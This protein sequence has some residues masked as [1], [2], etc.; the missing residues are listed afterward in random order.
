MIQ[1]RRG[2]VEIMGDS[3]TVVGWING[4][5]RERTVG[6]ATGSIH[7]QM[8]TSW[9]DE[10]NMVRLAGLFTYPQKRRGVGRNGV[11]SSQR[12]CIR[13][14]LVGQECDGTSIGDFQK[15]NRICSAST[16]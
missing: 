6:G 15:P 1:R 10:A 5:E 4:D 14:T 16:L 13:C 7:R 2:Q 3:K 11:P 9:R 8:H 12:T